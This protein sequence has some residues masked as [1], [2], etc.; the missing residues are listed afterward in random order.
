MVDAPEQVQAW[1]ASRTFWVRHFW[2]PLLAAVV[3]LSAL[4][5]TT[6]D[7]WLA[8][9]WFALEGG[10]WAWRNSWASYQLIHH[11]GKQFIIALGGIALSLAV[12]GFFIP[13]WRAWRAPMFYL[14]TTMGLVP[15][16]IAFFKRV[17]PVHCPWDL[18]RY[19]GNLPYVRT[20]DH[21][22]T[23]TSL[24]HCFPSGHASA[25]FILLAM[26]FAALPFVRSPARFL[27]PGFV[28]GWIFALGQQSRGGHFLSHDLWTLA[29]CWF[30]A[31]GMFLLFRPET[32]HPSSAKPQP[33]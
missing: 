19:G 16:A 31:L 5:Q 28:V 9:Q 1:H 33:L 17:S 26:Y 22:F 24:G 13:R 8:D 21:H 14:F 15:A 32:W 23:L 12:L 27:L 18:G 25:G 4:E 10:Q 2:L 6:L 7:L 20:F 29:I 30:G 3:V 11:H